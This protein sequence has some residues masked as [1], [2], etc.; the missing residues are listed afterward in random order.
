MS[1]QIVRLNS[2]EELLCHTESTPNGYYNLTDVA[3]LIPTRE[4]SIGLMPFMPY[5]KASE[6]MSI[7][8]DFI[9]FITDPVEGL[10]EQHQQMFSR[11]IT[12]NSKIVL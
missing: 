1:I 9:A 6:S 4:K 7:K 11:I 5:S 2:G 12:R 10:I 8:T 3:I